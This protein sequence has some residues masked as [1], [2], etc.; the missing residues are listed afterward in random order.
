MLALIE[1]KL[2]LSSDLSINSV[3]S[4]QALDNALNINIYK[5]YKGS[6]TMD[7]QNLNGKITFK[8]TN[9]VLFLTRVNNFCQKQ[10]GRMGTKQKV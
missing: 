8:T 6:F 3:T 9:S 5:N 10:L 2:S 4:I 7:K 1:D